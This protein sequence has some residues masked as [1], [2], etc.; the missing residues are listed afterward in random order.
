MLVRDRV[1]VRRDTK[2]LATAGGGPVVPDNGFRILLTLRPGS[3]G[4]RGADEFD[5]INSPRHCLV[6]GGKHTE[7]YNGRSRWA[8]RREGMDGVDDRSRGGEARGAINKG[9]PKKCGASVV[10][11]LGMEQELESWAARVSS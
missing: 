11:T 8:V 5:P 10:D 1:Y 9:S 7:L 4:W 6:I 2:S 3:G